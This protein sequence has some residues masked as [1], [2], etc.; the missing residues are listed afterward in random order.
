MPAAPDP[1]APLSEWVAAIRADV[2]AS[3][4]LSAESAKSVAGAAPSLFAFLGLHGIRT[5][6]ETE[7]VVLL[8]WAEEPLRDRRG[9]GLRERDPDEERRRRWKLRHIIAAAIRLGAPVPLCDD[10]GDLI[11]FLY[12]APRPKR[13]RSDPEEIAAAVAAWRPQRWRHGSLRNLSEV[14]PEVRERV[15]AA[16][17]DDVDD[18]RRWL[19][20][21]AGF[22]LWARD[23]RH[24]D[25]VTMHTPNNVETWV[26]R[27]NATQDDNWKNRTRGVLRKL[28]PTV[29]PGA[30][31]R[32]PRPLPPR[33]VVAPYAPKEERAFRAAASLPRQ[34]RRARLWVVIS[35]PGAGLN[36]PD[37]SAAEYDDLAQ[38]ADGRWEIGVRGDRARRVA[39]RREYSA[40]AD[41]LAAMQ[42]RSRFIA[43][44]KPGAVNQ[45]AQRIRVGDQSL[46]LTKSRNTFLAAHI[47]AGTPPAALSRVAGSV[48]H[49]TITQL[50]RH[51]AADLS[52]ADAVE[53]A[54]GA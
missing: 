31:P 7:G 46:S 44:D 18:A 24:S 39:I 21:L 5:W 25:P 40:L 12:P 29:N 8:E 49:D 4:G 6:R 54:L 16:E 45:I 51:V 50:I 47:A 48:T 2:R 22:A 30:W 9:E 10:G 43:S 19:R 27:V 23:D 41:E 36:G 34:D 38:R 33:K 26:M 11:R 53:Q 17:P 1:G 35:A 28:G 15:L 42:D 37:I 20:V 32:P 14:L 3:S 52:D 13:D